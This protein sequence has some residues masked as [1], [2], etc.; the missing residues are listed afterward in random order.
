M[1]VQLEFILFARR[2]PGIHAGD[3]TEEIYQQTSA[4][5]L[6]LRNEVSK[7]RSTQKRIWK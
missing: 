1:P 4:D 3:E 5:I 7:L 6:E 2:K